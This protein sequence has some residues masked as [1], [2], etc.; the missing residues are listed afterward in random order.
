[1]N[2]FAWPL[3]LSQKCVSLLVRCRRNYKI[4][5]KNFVKSN[6]RSAGGEISRGIAELDVVSVTQIHRPASCFVISEKKSIAVH[7]DFFLNRFGKRTLDRLFRDNSSR[8]V[9]FL[10]WNSIGI[11]Y[12]ILFFQ[13]RKIFIALMICQTTFCHPQSLKLPDIRD[14][15]P[16]E[17]NDLVQH[18]HRTRS[19]AETPDIFSLNN[20]EETIKEV[21]GMLKANPTLPRLTRGEIL[22]LLE[23]ITKTDVANG[24]PFSK[25]ETNGKAGRDPKAIMVVM[26]YTPSNGNDVS[27]EELFTK[28]PVTHIVGAEP[29]Q[30]PPGDFTF[31]RLPP[32]ISNI[33]ELGR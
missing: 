12:E 13:I 27:M 2:I 9:S 16:S 14:I 5:N 1:M 21:E 26:P 25:K 29:F 30:K 33:P 11:L 32:E 17:I 8:C 7:P 15:V 23:N 24:K 20:V 22:D 19:I 10:L 4:E 6:D 18:N 31:K 3:Y 28:P